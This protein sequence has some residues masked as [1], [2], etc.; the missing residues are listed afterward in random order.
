[1]HVD[2]VRSN[3]VD[4][5]RYRADQ[6]C[7]L[8]FAA[9]VLVGGLFLLAFED[10]VIAEAVACV[11]VGQRDVVDGLLDLRRV[12]FVFGIEQLEALA[13]ENPEAAAA[14]LAQF[15]LE[16][17]AVGGIDLELDDGNASAG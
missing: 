15:L 13:E 6:A 10:G 4:M 16:I 17:V 14:Q 8:P 11:L 9:G 7:S 1:M 3:G 12:L 2:A 5:F